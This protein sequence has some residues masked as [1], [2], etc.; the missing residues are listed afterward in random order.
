ST[1]TNSPILSNAIYL[2]LAENYTISNNIINNVNTNNNEHNG[3]FFAKGNGKIFGNKITNHQGNAVRAWLFSISNTNALVE[4]YDNIVY[5][6]TR[7]GAF[8]LQ[9]RDDIKAL[10]TFKPANAKIHNNTVGRLNTGEP[11]YFE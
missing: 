5:N 3:I 7:Y 11:K 8:E 6:S 9:V 1:I 4:I 10:P 2:G